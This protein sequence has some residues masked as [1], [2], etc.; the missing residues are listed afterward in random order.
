M[1]LIRSYILMS[2][3]YVYFANLIPKCILEKEKKKTICI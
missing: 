3:L 2:H 1:N